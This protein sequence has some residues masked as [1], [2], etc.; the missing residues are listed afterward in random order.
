MHPTLAYGGIIKTINIF[1]SDDCPP[2]RNAKEYLDAHN[3][4]YSE[5]NVNNLPQHTRRLFSLPT[6]ICK[7]NEVEVFKFEGFSLGIG[8]RMNKWYSN[9]SPVD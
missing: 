1:T 8:N 9:T 6:I 3:I 7:N 5:I 4:K 2:C